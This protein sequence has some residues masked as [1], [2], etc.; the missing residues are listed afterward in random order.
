MPSGENNRNRGK[1]SK[2][3]MRKEFTK[4]A[5]HSLPLVWLLVLPTAYILQWHTKHQKST[6]FAFC[7]YVLTNHVPL[8][9]YSNQPVRPIDCVLHYHKHYGLLLAKVYND[10]PSTSKT[11]MRLVLKNIN[12]NPKKYVCILS[13][14]AKYSV[15]TIGYFHA[16]VHD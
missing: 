5:G 1:K 13:L 10:C 12:I 2:E 16:M 9:K 7:E 15:F 6:C 8:Y 11:F 14:E 3:E 4:M